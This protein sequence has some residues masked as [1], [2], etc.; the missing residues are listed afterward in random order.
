MTL[1][2]PR[3]VARVLAEQKG[4]ERLVH[5]RFRR[6]RGRIGFPE[7]D[8]P[9]VRVQLAQSPLIAPACTVMAA[10]RRIVSIAVM[11]MGARSVADSGG[12]SIGFVR[13]VRLME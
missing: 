6:G 13:L 7:A 10:R 2:Q 1:P 11:R 9:L 5:R 4:R 3:D 12:K 8:Q